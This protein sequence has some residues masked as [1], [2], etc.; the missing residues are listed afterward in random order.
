M[1]LRRRIEDPLG[2]EW[3]RKNII[4]LSPTVGLVDTVIGNNNMI[5]YRLM[6]EATIPYP[7]LSTLL[8]RANG[9]II[10]S[11]RSRHGEALKVA[12]MLQGGGHANAC[13]ATLPKSIRNIPDAITYLCQ[14]LNPAKETHAPASLESL[15]A[16]IENKPS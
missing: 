4:A 10:V 15:F 16:A 6:E 5:L 13:G 12:E 11:L 1:A 14:V 9:Q 3:S 7:V 2:L 8:R